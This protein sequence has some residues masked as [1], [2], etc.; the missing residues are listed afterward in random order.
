MIW[1]LITIQ[2]QF[3]EKHPKKGFVLKVW[4]FN[5]CRHNLVYKPLGLLFN[6]Q[7]WHDSPALT[8]IIN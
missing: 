3:K 8:F 6:R 4:R 1:D 5:N 7:I 2:L